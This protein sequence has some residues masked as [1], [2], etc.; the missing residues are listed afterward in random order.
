MITWSL[1]QASTRLTEALV[2]QRH[3]TL[4]KPQYRF[5]HHGV[6]RHGAVR[7]GANTPQKN[8]QTEERRCKSFANN[9][10][11]EELSPQSTANPIVDE[12]GMVVLGHP[13]DLVSISFERWNQKR[14]ETRIL[15]F[16]LPGTGIAQPSASAQTLTSH[17]ST[18]T[19]N[20]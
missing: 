20:R 14:I 15:L 9:Y 10:Y 3:L 17:L 11:A 5:Q 16:L 8:T 2:E 1:T 12:L 18:L 7:R 19:T 13:Q 4:C 6:G